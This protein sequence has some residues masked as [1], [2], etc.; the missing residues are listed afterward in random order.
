[1]RDTA[2]TA[3]ELDADIKAEEVEL[4]AREAARENIVKRLVAAV[5]PLIQAAVTERQRFEAKLLWDKA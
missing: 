4:E 3:E 2:K 5:V 1:M